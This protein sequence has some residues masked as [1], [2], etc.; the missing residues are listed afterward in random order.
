VQIKRAILKLSGEILKGS[1]DSGLDT[2]FVSFLC[3][4]IIEACSLGVQLAL[5]VG[6]GNFV[7]GSKLEKLGID[8]ATADYMGMLATIINSLAIQST[9]EAKGLPTRVMSAIEIRQVCE[10][11]IRRRAIRHLE[12]NRVV[13]FAAGLGSPF[14]TTD[15]VAS[16]RA[17]EIGADLVIKGTKVDGIYTV[18][19][20]IGQGQKLDEVSYN[21]FLL[22][23]LRVLDST[24]VSLSKDY[25]V[26]I[27]VLKISEKGNLVKLLKGERVGSLITSGTA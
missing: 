27:V 24:A 13:I 18:D 3:D 7:R 12:K 22:N 23:N 11:Y 9:L 4:E 15:T 6:G 5:V 25:Q 10:P 16:L 20:E 2:E 17:L 19:P 8:R 21:Y 1:Q 14:F 26:P